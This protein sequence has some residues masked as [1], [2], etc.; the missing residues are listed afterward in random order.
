[1]HEATLFWAD[2]LYTHFIRAR[3]SVFP[4]YR[5]KII[6]KRHRNNFKLFLSGRKIFQR[7]QAGADGTSIIFPAKCCD[8][9]YGARIFGLLFYQRTETRKPQNNNA[10]STS[11][12]IHKVLGILKTQH[13]HT[14]AHTFTWNQSGWYI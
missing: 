14:H 5:N 6:Y 1:L 4:V 10:Y 12:S 11:F 2:R 8:I 13:P 3:A 9:V 7:I